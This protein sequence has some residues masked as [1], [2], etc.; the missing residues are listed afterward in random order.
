MLPLSLV[1]L[2]TAILF[3]M[4]PALVALSGWC[5]Y[6]SLREAGG[7]TTAGPAR[8][9]LGGVLVAAELAFAFLLLMGA[10]LMLRTF[11]NLRAV[12][13]GFNPRN[14]LTIQ[15]TLTANKIP[16]SCPA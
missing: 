8:Q 10:G 14:L 3:S 6:C 1:S 9:K 12:S 13:P 2:S 16:E 5:E 15:V 11:A 4:A 7:K